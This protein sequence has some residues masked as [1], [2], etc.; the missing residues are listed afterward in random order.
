MA[1]ITVPDRRSTGVLTVLESQSKTA[2]NK[3]YRIPSGFVPA[4]KHEV[5]KPAGLEGIAS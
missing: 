3:S 2:G 1:D 5:K 4:S